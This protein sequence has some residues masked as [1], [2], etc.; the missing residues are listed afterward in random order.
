[1]NQTGHYSEDFV[2]KLFLTVL[3]I[4]QTIIVIYV[5]QVIMSIHLEHVIKYPI[6]AIKLIIITVS[7]YNVKIQHLYYKMENA[8]KIYK[9]V[10]HMNYHQE[11]VNS[12]CS[13]T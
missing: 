8:I 2:I 3:I 11:Y 4:T 1:M 6:T 10:W 7:V 5:N 13:D 12:V 9:I